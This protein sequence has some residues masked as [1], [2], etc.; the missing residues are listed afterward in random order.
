MTLVTLQ[1]PVHWDSEI[2]AKSCSGD[3]EIA[4]EDGHLEGFVSA[5]YSIWI[6][7]DSSSFL[8]GMTGCGT[9]L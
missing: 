6:T 3:S 5:F 2:P 1:N 7:A 4:T 8:L 9:F